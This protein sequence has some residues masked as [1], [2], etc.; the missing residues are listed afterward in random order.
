[1]NTELRIGLTFDD[2]LL[3][4]AQ[5]DISPKDVN[6]ATRLTKT[7]KLN[8]PIMSAGMDTVTESKM[9]IAMARQG[10]V[11]VIHKN[12]TIERQATEVDRVKRSEH[13]VITDPFSLSQNNYV[14]EANSVMAKYRISGVPITENGRLIG[15][16]TNRDLRFETDHNKKIYEVM[17]RENLVTAPVGTTLEEAKR[18]L[19]RH[20]LE[21][22]PIVDNKGNLKGLIT[23]KDIQKTIKY[24]QSAKDSQGRLLVGAAVGTNEHFMKRVSALVE[25]KVD[26][27]VLDS[28]HGHS[29]T[30]I[31]CLR[32][33]K[34]AFPELQ[35]VPGMWRPGK[36][37]S[38]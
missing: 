26:V 2:I 7:I 12:M 14:H 17:T 10:G 6:L 27:L 5:S 25:E 24:P 21:K 38:R 20:K 11:G 1:V 13:G 16:I 34:S 15:I 35:V 9:A 31:N 4:P 32:E 33:I 3:V 28:A 37:P 18:I 8:N 36:R 30:V 22:L 19:V 29:L 23:I